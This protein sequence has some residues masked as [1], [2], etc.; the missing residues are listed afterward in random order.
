MMQRKGC[1]L[2]QGLRNSQQITGVPTCIIHSTQQTVCRCSNSQFP[3][4]AC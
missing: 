4:A 1:L 3:S 2:L